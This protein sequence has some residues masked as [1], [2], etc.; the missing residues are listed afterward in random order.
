MDN[1]CTLQLVQ[2]EVARLVDAETVDPDTGVAE[3]GIDSLNVVELMF[4][5]EL[6]YKKAIQLEELSLDQFTTL[7]ELDQQLRR[8]GS[9]AP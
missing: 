4:A 9:L 5:L 6:L 8:M 1:C 2:R 7:R 3:L